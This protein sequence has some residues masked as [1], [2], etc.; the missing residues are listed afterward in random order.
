MSKAQPQVQPQTRVTIGTDPEFF[1]RNKEDN[2]WESAI[3]IIEGTKDNPEKLPSGSALQWD[4]VALEFAT[5]PAG[6]V[7][8]MIEKIRETFLDLKDKLPDNLEVVAQPSAEFSEDKLLCDEAR[9]FGCDP[10]YD[11]WELMQ[12]IPPDPDTTTL[13]SCGG[14]IHVGYTE[15]CGCEFLHDTFGKFHTIRLMDTFHGIISVVLDNS[16]AAIRRRELYGKAG[17]YRSTDY[18]VEYRVLSNFWLKSPDLV[19]LMDSL[20]QDVLNYMKRYDYEFLTDLDS[21]FDIVNT[22]GAEVIQN[23]INKSDVDMA[24]TMVDK[25]LNPYLSDQTKDLLQIALDINETSIEKE[26][27]VI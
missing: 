10:D 19:R 1:L 7:E 12:N 13:R 22:I 2:A 26:W 17:C 4:N 6:D 25:H 15:G 16:E 20:V 5:P 8:E 14:H 27:E 3:D 23:T 18:G 9:M 11:A 21:E 24:K